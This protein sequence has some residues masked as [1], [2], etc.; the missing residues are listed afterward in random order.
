M[1]LMFYHIVF[2]EVSKPYGIILNKL[3][4]KKPAC[5]GNV[6]KNLELEPGIDKSRGSGNENFDF[7][8]CLETLRNKGKF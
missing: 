4:I 6:S 1:L 5:I 3:K 7:G 2:L 8:T